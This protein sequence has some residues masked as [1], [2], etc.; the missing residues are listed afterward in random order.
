[1]A[2][3]AVKL[4][5]KPTLIGRIQ[6]AKPTI[7]ASAS[8]AKVKSAGDA[9]GGLSKLPTSNWRTSIRLTKTTLQN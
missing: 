3:D 6:E 8:E 5:I 2:V 4:V 7:V 9:E 1:M